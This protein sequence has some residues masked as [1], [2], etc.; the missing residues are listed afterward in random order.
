[1]N[2]AYDGSGFFGWQRQTRHKTVQGSIETALSQIL[3]TSTPLYGAGRT[4]AGVHALSQ[5]AHFEARAIPQDLAHRLNR[6]LG[7]QIVI[8]E[9]SRVDRE[10]HARFSAK[11]R[12]YRYEISPIDQPHRRHNAWLIAHEWP[13]EQTLN[14]LAQHIEGIH[15]FAGFAKNT[16]DLQHTQCHVFESRWVA[17]RKTLHYH[18]R[19]NRFLRSMVRRLVAAQLHIATGENAQE[20]FIESL[21]HP[22]KSRFLDLAPPQ[23]LILMQVGY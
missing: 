21:L 2:I 7:A 14:A 13:T 6:M 11:W 23:G 10:F 3:N 22:Q 16:P 17:S 18:I 20:E 12:S 19:A 5:T 1:M 4:D 15:D 8:T 9:I